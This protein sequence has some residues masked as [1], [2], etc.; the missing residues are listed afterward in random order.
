[1][2][3]HCETFNWNG[4]CNVLFNESSEEVQIETKGVIVL[5]EMVTGN[6]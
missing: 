2:A 1:M 6:R 5:R 4:F 3:N